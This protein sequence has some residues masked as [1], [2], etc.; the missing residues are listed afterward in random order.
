MKPQN[1]AE[2]AAMF[3]KV[4]AWRKE[5]QDAGDDVRLIL[6]QRCDRRAAFHVL[7]DLDAVCLENEHAPVAAIDR[8]DV[9]LLAHDL[10]KARH[11][12]EVAA[13]RQ[14]VAPN[15]LP[16]ILETCGIGKIEIGIQNGRRIDA[17]VV[18]RADDVAG[19]I[20]EAQG[21]TPQYGPNPRRTIDAAY[22]G[23]PVSIV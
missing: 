7:L 14:R 18:D 20:V 23:R 16:A 11:L 2:R 10:V 19:L 21:E 8:R 3:R 6:D 5:R 1:A 17:P 15:I 13:D 22:E 9:R 4:F 12:V